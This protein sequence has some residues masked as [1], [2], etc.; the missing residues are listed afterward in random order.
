MSQTRPK[1]LALAIGAAFTAGTLFSMQAMAGGYMQDTAASQAKA[2]KDTPVP[3]HVVNS[4]TNGLDKKQAASEGKCGEGKC[5]ADM[6]AGNGDKTASPR[7][8]SSG[9]A[10][11]KRTHK[12]MVMKDMDSDKDGRLSR[13]EFIAAHKP[14]NDGGVTAM[15][16]WEAPAAKAFA[17]H[18][19]DGDGFISQAE[20]DQHH[21]DMKA[22]ASEGKCGEGKCGG[23]M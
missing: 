3:G 12:P 6:M 2:A 10:T 18:D 22:K 23:K 21:A 9:Q 13:A 5:G 20:M 19:A 17:E 8:A 4:H 7:D 16:D 1:S 11:G 15:D 14:A